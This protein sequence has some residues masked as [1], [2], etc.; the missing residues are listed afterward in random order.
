MTDK[1]FR[2]KPTTVKAWTVTE[3][4]CM[5]FHNGFALPEPI[6]KLYENREFVFYIASVSFK[7]DGRW[8]YAET[9]DVIVSDEDNKLHIYSKEQ[10]ERNFEVSPVADIDSWGQISPRDS[11]DIRRGILDKMNFGTPN[12]F[13]KVEAHQV[14]LENREELAEWCG[15]E[16]LNPNH[17]TWCIMLQEEDALNTQYA[18]E[19]DFIV[20]DGETYYDWSEEEF[21]KHH[22]R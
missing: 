8:L 10:F 1:T 17:L 3:L 7:Q 14:T 13:Q 9:D 15:G 22:V 4:T 20:F 18:Y 19:G 2:R 21:Y 6:Q 12:W 5:A 16:L 11:C